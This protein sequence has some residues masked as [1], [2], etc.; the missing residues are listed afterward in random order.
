LYPKGSIISA[1]GRPAQEVFFLHKGCV[2]LYYH[3]DGEQITAA[4]PLKAALR[5]HA[6]A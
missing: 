4:F 6:K 2:R 1:E 3:R 5:G